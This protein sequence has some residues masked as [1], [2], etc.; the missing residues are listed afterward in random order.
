MASDH[1]RRSETPLHWLRDIIRKFP[2]LRTL[3]RG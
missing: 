1:E 3:N 2:V